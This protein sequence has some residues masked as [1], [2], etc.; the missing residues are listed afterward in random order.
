MASS[1]LSG[2]T[3]LRWVL[4]APRRAWLMLGVT[5]LLLL[6]A[7]LALRLAF[8]AKDAAFPLA[9]PDPRLLAE[10]YDN[11][12]W[13]P[14]IFAALKHVPTEWRAFEL[15]QPAPDPDSPIGFDPEGNRSTL[16]ARG[17]PGPV[18]GE[19]SI[20]VF[21]SSAAWGWGARSDLT[22]PSQLATYLV[23]S[24]P[25]VRVHNFAQPGYVSTQDALALL[26]KLRERE[27][28][29]LVI[30]YSGVNDVLA[31]LQNGRAGLPQN[32]ANRQRE[33]NILTRP[34]DLARSFV[35]AVVS[36]SA[37]NRLATSAARRLLPVRPVPTK[38][39]GPEQA[40]QL[41]TAYQHNMHLAADL[42]KRYGFPVLA[43]WQPTLFTKKS[44]RPYETEKA[45]QYAWLREPIAQV[46][47]LIDDGRLQ[48]LPVRFADLR[49]VLDDE[50]KLVFV[51]FCHTT[52]HANVTIAGV[53]AEEVQALLAPSS[54][55]GEPSP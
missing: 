55:P 43:C 9:D 15:Y 11:A 19:P 31:S 54:S 10:G 35:E 53:L 17:G 29:D 26:M 37:F 50:K 24:K 27:P 46:D 22:I 32:E 13:T 33:F 39:F 25:T 28:P 34:G 21:G 36:A 14:A 40:E 4:R 1:S 41:L 5:L 30:F 48:D 47:R 51:D 18:E 20:W 45:N 7:E 16:D 42:G 52:E 3:A 12:P 2:K 8:L 6:A 38:P 49:H 23:A 44:M